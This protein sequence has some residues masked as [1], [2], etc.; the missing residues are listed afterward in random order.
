MLVLER[1][2]HTPEDRGC[3]REEQHQFQGAAAVGRRR[4]ERNYY[5][6]KVRRGG[7][8]KI[9][10]LQGGGIFAGAALKRY[11]TSKVREP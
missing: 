4:A 5:T 7:S 2:Y 10:L 11:P 9:P 6:F 8:E 3:G 1:S